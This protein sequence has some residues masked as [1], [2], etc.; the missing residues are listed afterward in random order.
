MLALAESRGFLDIEHG[1]E[2]MTGVVLAITEAGR[3]AIGAVRPDRYSETLFRR[4]LE[5]V[6]LR[7]SP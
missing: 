1:S 3:E 5:Y 6:K 2:W 7:A 4:M